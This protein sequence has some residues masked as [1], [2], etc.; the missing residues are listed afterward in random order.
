MFVKGSERTLSCGGVCGCG[1]G[2]DHV[3]LPLLPTSVFRL[4]V[5]VTSHS[6]TLESCSFYC[7]NDK[8]AHLYTCV[9]THT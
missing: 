4:L 8:N 5:A 7:S 6:L 1:C 2:G 9:R 3:S